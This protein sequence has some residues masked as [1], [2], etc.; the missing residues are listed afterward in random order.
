MNQCARVSKTSYFF[1][2]DL[3]K[4]DAVLLKIALHL[5]C[6]GR[7]LW[8]IIFISMTTSDLLRIIILVIQ[9]AVVKCIQVL[10][11]D[12]RKFFVLLFYRVDC[13]HIFNLK[14]VEW[15][16]KVLKFLIS[17]KIQWSKMI[18]YWWHFLW[19]KI[20]KKYVINKNFPI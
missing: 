7:F 3:R 14:E 13:V 6:G 10:K 2:V 8:F 19:F 16:K 18:L 11:F 9:C 12:M 20:N 1:G 4:Y 17:V 15:T 5:F